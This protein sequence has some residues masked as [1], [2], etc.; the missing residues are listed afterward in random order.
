MKLVNYSLLLVAVSL[1]FACKNEGE[2]TSAEKTGGKSTINLK[3]KLDTISYLIGY[4]NGQGL[5]M[6]GIDEVNKG[7]MADALQEALSGKE[8]AIDL[9]EASVI[10]REYMIEKRDELMATNKKDG[11]EFLEKNKSKKGVVTTESGLQYKVIKE[12]NGAKPK[13][14]DRISVNY[15]GTT[16]DGKEFDASKEGV[17]AEFVV[18]QVVQGWNE[19][20]QLM[21]VGS[22][23]EFYIPSELAYGQ[24]GRPG[25]EPNSVLL[26]NVELLDIVEKK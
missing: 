22:T 24:R 7:I 1:L 11:E 19:G 15:R 13:M 4:S 25:I 16:I 5:A 8:A 26:F 18:G 10:V 2:S 12:G 23:Y 9:Q 3:T 6:Q 20:L 17:P 21:P 14:G